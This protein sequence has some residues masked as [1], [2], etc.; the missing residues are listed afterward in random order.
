MN[1]EVKHIDFT[2]GLAFL[3]VVQKKTIADKWFV[4]DIILIVPL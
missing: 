3:T 4:K 1:T 2:C